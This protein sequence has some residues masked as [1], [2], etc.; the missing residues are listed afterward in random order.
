[1]NELHF[2][3]ELDDDENM[4]ENASI[5]V[6][7]FRYCKNNTLEKIVMY[8]NKLLFITMLSLKIMLQD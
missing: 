4:F 1:M 2:N 8:N 7:V 6:I 3:V 5:D